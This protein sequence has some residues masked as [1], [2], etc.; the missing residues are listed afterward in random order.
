M[1]SVEGQ[2]LHKTLI[3]MMGVSSYSPVCTGHGWG[4]V[5]LWSC[6]GD[7]TSDVKV[8]SD[9]WATRSTEGFPLQSKSYPLL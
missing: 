2:L 1:H 8:L 9:N 5:P 6:R 4:L 7:G 3:S